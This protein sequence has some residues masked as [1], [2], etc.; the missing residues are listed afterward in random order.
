MIIRHEDGEPYLDV[1]LGIEK[2]ILGFEIPMSN[3]LIM[4]V[5]NAAEDLL[6][7]AFDLAWAHTPEKKTN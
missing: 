2:Q 5:L 7:T 1:T 3:T 4:K 6:K